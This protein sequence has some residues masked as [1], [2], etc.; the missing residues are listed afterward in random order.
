MQI[1]KKLR[2]DN[3]GQ[4]RAKRGVSSQ[5]RIL[6]DLA[7]PVVFLFLHT[8]PNEYIMKTGAC[9]AVFAFFSVLASNFENLARQDGLELSEAS[10]HQ[11]EQVFQGDGFGTQ[12]N[13]RDSPSS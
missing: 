5:L 11:G 13:D 9:Q 3:F 2:E 10:W 12:D 6:K 1:L 4:N 7:P 8:V